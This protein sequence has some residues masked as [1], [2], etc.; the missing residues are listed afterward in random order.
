MAPRVAT[1]EYCPRACT[2]SPFLTEAFV[3]LNYISLVSSFE[4]VN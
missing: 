1:G 3:M 4:V 2:I